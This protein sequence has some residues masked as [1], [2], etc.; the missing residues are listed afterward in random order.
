MLN[1][2][3]VNAP[4]TSTLPSDTSLECL[5]EPTLISDYSSFLS[6]PP[7]PPEITAVPKHILQVEKLYFSASSTA[8]LP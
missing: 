8:V 7:P 2:D 3:L 5:E 6:T 1:K 4:A